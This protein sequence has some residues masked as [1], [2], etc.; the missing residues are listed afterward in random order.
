MKKLIAFGVLFLMT[1]AS[2]ATASPLPFSPLLLK[3]P[4]V[5]TVLK[6]SDADLSAISNYSATNS[7]PL[8]A[9]LINGLDIAKDVM[10][11]PGVKNKIPMP[12]LK[13][14]NGFRP[15]SGSEAYKQK[16][17]KYTDRYLEVKVGVR[18]LLIDPEDYRQTYLIHST[19]PG[20]DASKKEIPFAQFMWDQVL[21]GVQREVNDETAYKGFDGSATPDYN[22]G[23]AYTAASAAIVK[24]AS[25]NDN[26]LNVKDWYMCVTDAAIGHT[27]DTHPAK[28]LNVT[29][30]AVTPGIESY[31]LA[32]IAASEISPVA[33]GAITSTEGVAVAAFKKLFRAWTPAYRNNGIIISCSY[34][35]W[36]LLVDDLAAKFKY[37]KADEVKEQ[38]WLYLPECDRKCIVKPATWLGTS[39]R[40]VSG[41]VF[42]DGQNPKQ[43]NLFMATDLLSDLNQIATLTQA[44]LWTILAGLK[45]C[46]GFNYQDPEGIKV[47]D[48][49]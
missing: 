23:A 21:K 24:F 38:Q 37:I 14:G 45:A 46:L 43:M 18:E 17:L 15:Y 34:T 39:R 27:P 9:S 25:A 48:Q 13:V 26:P 28:W 16:A 19:S 35:D 47:G 32:G 31:I 8:I 30:R 5:Y 42:W 3:A 33:T 11:H 4:Q 7:K 49:V 12:K 10:V 6:L 22:A 29:A 44:K 1:A 36:D 40:L 20:S 2:I 41:P